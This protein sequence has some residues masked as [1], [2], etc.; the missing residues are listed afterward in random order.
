MLDPTNK[1]MGAACCAWGG[2]EPRLR[3]A[4]WPPLLPALPQQQQQML[5][6]SL[7]EVVDHGERER[8]LGQDPTI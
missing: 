4:S 7:Q 6:V 2:Q 5:P 3:W 1:G 8:G